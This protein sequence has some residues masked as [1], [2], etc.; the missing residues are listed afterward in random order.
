MRNT[1]NHGVI[2]RVPY[3]KSYDIL[4]VMSANVRTIASKVD[5]IQQI[6]ELNNANTIC[7][8]ETWLPPRCQMLLF[9]SLDTIYFGKIGQKPREEC[10]FI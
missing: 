2:K 5:K 7:I 9:L 6:A 1:V 10:V 4:T 3:R 8:T